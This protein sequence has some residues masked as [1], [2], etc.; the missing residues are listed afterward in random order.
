MLIKNKYI[1][2]WAQINTKSREGTVV[3]N[4][5]TAW[6]IS[7][8]QQEKKAMEDIFEI[9]YCARDLDSE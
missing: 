4:K 5:S 3:Y 7:D 1:V 2:D 6:S 9:S 8:G